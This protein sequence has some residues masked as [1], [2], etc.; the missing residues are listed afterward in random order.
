MG[1]ES[2]GY[3]PQDINKFTEYQTKEQINEEQGKNGKETPLE[4]ALKEG[5]KNPF[6]FFSNLGEGRYGNDITSGDIK[7]ILLSMDEELRTNFFE[8]MHIVKNYLKDENEFFDTIKSFIE[9]RNIYELFIF[10]ED[11]SLFFKES[12][13][14]TKQK[15]QKLVLEKTDNLGVT[16]YHISFKSIFDFVE[17]TKTDDEIYN[18]LLNKIFRLSQSSKKSFLQNFGRFSDLFEKV[19]IKNN[20]LYQQKIVGIIKE[21]PSDFLY[22]FD[23]ICDFV[24]KEEVKNIIFSFYGIETTNSNNPEIINSSTFLKYFDKIYLF[25]ENGDKS[26]I[27]NLIIKSLS[28]SPSAYSISS[29][30]EKMYSFIEK[31]DIENIFSPEIIIKNSE[32]FNL[33]DNEILKHWDSLTNQK[34]EENEETSEDVK[35]KERSKEDILKTLFNEYFYDKLFLLI[36]HAIKND[37]EYT[38]QTLKNIIEKTDLKSVMKTFVKADMKN[39]II[40]LIKIVNLYGI[41]IENFEEIESFLQKND[42]NETK[43]NSENET[44]EKENNEKLDIFEE[45]FNFYLIPFIEN[46]LNQY[47]E[48]QNRI[49]KVEFSNVSDMISLSEMKSKE[50]TLVENLKKHLV[51]IVN[52]EIKTFELEKDSDRLEIYDKNIG[53]NLEKAKLLFLRSVDRFTE[54]RID[55]CGGENW[56]NIS[57]VA[58]FAFSNQSDEFKRISIDRVFDLQH[59]T[60]SVFTKK[61]DLFD[62]VNSFQSEKLQK[63]LDFK[64]ENS[65]PYKYLEY[66]LK[67]GLMSEDKYEFY[68]NLLNAPTRPVG[69]E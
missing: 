32:K 48:K 31:K 5:R 34:I 16:A 21:Y 4:E 25:I 44:K 49:S 55:G 62:E 9:G 20:D 58:F 7:E 8:I 6:L 19:D 59:N 56:K 64:K 43:T 51:E 14:E 54:Q 23:E 18:E 33:T 27:K 61:T 46:K 2:S 11:I 45:A 12:D 10:L 1:I 39:Q 63:F 66:G 26:K 53:M 24:N 57:E 50:K 13:N 42:E 67:N 17:N 28:D 38:K 52:D 22:S 29:F 65:D 3:K 40:Q 30:S 15:L 69:Y 47:D 37:D 60:G 36:D 41:K 35:S 68:K